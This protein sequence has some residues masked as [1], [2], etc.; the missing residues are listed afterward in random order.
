M[1]VGKDPRQLQFDG[2]LWTQE[3]VRQ[4]IEQTFAVTFT[5][6]GVGR[7]LRRLGLSPQRPLVRAYE[8]DPQRVRRWTEKGYP[9]IYRR[10]RPPGPASSSPTRPGCA[11]TTTWA[12]VG[13]TPVVVGTG[14]RL[15]V[16]MISAVSSQGKIHFSFLGPVWWI[17]TGV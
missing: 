9:A 3:M 5:P 17:L 10:P 1:I 6:Q 12:P 7:L 13:R 2:A 4:L 14:A 11:P 15:S 8:Q 16:N